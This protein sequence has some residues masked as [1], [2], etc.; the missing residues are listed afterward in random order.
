MLSRIADSLYWMARYLERVG[1]TARLMEINLTHM[2]EAEEAMS[3]ESIWKPVL[4]IGGHEDVYMQLHKGG[5]ITAPRVL[6]FMTQ[7]RRNPTSIR[8]CLRISREN[9]RAA[10]DRISK[11][12]WECINEFWLG[13]D[14][15]LKSPISPERGGELYSY[16][17]R[18]VARFNGVMLNTMLRGEP[19]SFCLLGSFIER[20]DMTARILDVKY[21]ILLPDISLV[22]SPLDYYQWA[23]LLKSLSGFEAFRRKHHAGLRPIEVAAFVIFEREFPRSLAFSSMMM[24]QAITNIGKGAGGETVRAMDDIDDLL[25]KSSPEYVFRFGLHEF[26][27]Q[28]LMKIYAL[29]TAVQRDFFETYLGDN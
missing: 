15:R 22:G 2:L 11:E 26:L 25:L 13:M 14:Q 4:S 23:A 1:N 19:Y 12:M 29:N 27:E 3:V 21:H 10:R 16:I 28:Y 17:R 7:E 20:A 24:R 9:A 8:S 6:Q 18:E 5:E